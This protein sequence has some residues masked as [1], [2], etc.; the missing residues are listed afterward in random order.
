[1][2]LDYA[3]ALR[4]KRMNA[5]NYRELCAQLAESAKKLGYI[6]LA[7]RASALVK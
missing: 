1:L 4:S 7:A 5:P 3:R 6:T 2:S